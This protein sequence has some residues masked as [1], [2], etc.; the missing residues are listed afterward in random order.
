M[1]RALRM[2][3]GQKVP[4]HGFRHESSY[5]ASSSINKTHF[6][7]ATI[8]F[9]GVTALWVWNTCLTW[10]TELDLRTWRSC[11]CSSSPGSTKTKGSCSSVG[12]TTFR[13]KWMVVSLSM[14]Y[15][16]RVLW[17]FRVFEPS[18]RTW[19]CMGTLVLYHTCSLISF[20]LCLKLTLKVMH[21]TVSQRTFTWTT[22]ARR[23]LLRMPAPFYILC[24]TA[25]IA[26]T[27][28]CQSGSPLSL[29][30]FLS[31]PSVVLLFLNFQSYNVRK[32]VI[33]LYDHISHPS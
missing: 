6:Q 33:F 31:L 27:F 19:S 5:C 16:D 15:D 18:W 4:W 28:H 30:H 2:K 10:A 26:P 8:S 12:F 14:P 11:L 3:H 13:V 32:A 17:D 23:L 22:K 20:V 1:H 25:L 9:L 29:Q 24:A 7:Q 21:P